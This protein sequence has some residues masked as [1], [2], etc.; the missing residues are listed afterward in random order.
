MNK[1]E[2]MGRLTKDVEKKMTKNKKEVYT[3]SIA[4][5]RKLDRE[6]VDFINCMAFGKLGETIEKY[7]S[8]G[9]KIIVCGSLEINTY[10]NKEKQKVSTPCIIVDDF[11]F[12]ESKKVNNEDQKADE[13]PF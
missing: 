1:I 10:E 8:K 7:T 6:V 5:P 11:Y 12:C 9:Q 13:L 4:V 3:F 2:L